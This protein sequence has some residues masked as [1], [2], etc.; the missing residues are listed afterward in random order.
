MNSVSVKILNFI[1]NEDDKDISLFI[2]IV[3]NYYYN[4]D[5]PTKE[6]E[7]KM[8]KWF[9]LDNLNEIEQF[10]SNI[11]DDQYDQMIEMTRINTN[12]DDNNIG[13]V[14]YH[15]KCNLPVFMGSL[16]KI[17]NVDG[18]NNWKK[19]M[20]C[21][22]ILVT[23]KLDGISA[24]LSID[25][26]EVKLCTRGN[27][28]IGCDISHL[29]KYLDIQD[30]I[31]NTL[32]TFKQSHL[33][34]HIRGELIME[35]YNKTDVSNLRNVV[36]G[37][38][39]TKEIT[40]DVRNKLKDV[41]FV[42]YRLYN[43]KYYKTQLET[44]SK[45]KYKVPQCT[46][47]LNL[48]TFQELTDTLILFSHKSKYQIDGIVVSFNYYHTDIDQI[49][50]NPEHSIAIKNIS[51]SK[52]T[53]VIEIE[54]N[55][56]KHGV[57]KP[58]VKIVPININGANIE[59]VTGF[60]AKYIYDN[61]I[62]KGTILEI[63]RSGDVIPN[64]KKV[65]KSTKADMPK[66]D[67][68]WNKTHVDIC[69]KE[70]HNDEMEIKKLLTFFQEMECPS[71]GP[72][73][74]ETLYEYG[75]KTI[76]DILELTK[77]DLLNTDK[78]KDKSAENVLSGIK[79]AKDFLLNI[80]DDNLHILMYSSG[81]FGF[82]FGSKKIK[83]ILDS[84]PNIIKEYNENDK[85]YWIKNIKSVKGI[86]EQ[87]E[88]FI[89]CIDKYRNFV[90]TMIKYIQYTNNNIETK[91]QK[92]TKKGE[93]VLSGFRDKSLKQTLEENGYI[94]NDNVTKETTIVVY[95]ENDNSTKCQKAKKMG[96]KLIQKNNILTLLNS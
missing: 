77:Q 10:L 22:E 63:E 9:K 5:L 34:I 27:G 32:N 41:H 8:K 92:T 31:D 50:K 69:I 48:P 19:K 75:F 1:D 72:K 39:H 38:V 53:E 91:K 30:M 54:W 46:I 78:F 67:W 20:S 93:V 26:K 6:Q 79:V 24:L 89:N 81:C 25:R 12:I 4:N 2:N 56:S 49:D 17:K 47:Y 64:I 16:D 71:L 68:E 55:V 14:P 96:I 51:E 83:L 28:K 80:N 43:E 73:T 61:Q 66:N 87:A 57:Y 62:G 90:K 42:A 45:L 74:I 88:M 36:S 40:Q 23:E 85:D 18:Y 76:L 29:I 84:Y 82:G 94:V 44:L 52:E 65:I 60:N 95:D 86:S 21:C 58:R 59:W 7:N 3:K 11:S 35:K 37:F 33:P 70:D 15:K 13:A